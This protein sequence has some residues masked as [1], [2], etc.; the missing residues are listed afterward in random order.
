MVINKTID[1]KKAT[2]FVE[3]KLDNNTSYAFSK[4]FD[5]VYPGVDEIVIDFS[6]LVYISSVG[7]RVLIVAQKKL[8]RDG[9]KLTLVNVTSDIM[10]IFD[11]TG[12]SKI[13]T[14]A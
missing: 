3:G 14:I 9:K 2:L 8:N 12:F 11:L 5:K 7:L 4:E 13:L 10:E 6:K 1:G